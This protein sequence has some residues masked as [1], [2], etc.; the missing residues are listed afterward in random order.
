[1]NATSEALP[2]AV[3]SPKEKHDFL[4]GVLKEVRAAVIDFMFKQAAILT[5]IMGW[6]ISSQPAQSFLAAHSPA[7]YAAAGGIAFLCLFLIAR[8][9]S[10]RNRSHSDYKFLLQLGYM[11]QEFYSRIVITWSLALS[12]ISLY[13]VACLVL[14]ICLFC[15]A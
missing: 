14:I 2:V 10:F 4:V 13:V 9:M 1:M 5:L 12:L 11:P 7:R 6:V 3:A 8:V 15:T